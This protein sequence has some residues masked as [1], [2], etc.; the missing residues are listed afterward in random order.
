ML[1]PGSTVQDIAN[2]LN[3]NSIL[4]SKGEFFAT[5]TSILC[6]DLFN[7]KKGELSRWMLFA[8][9]RYVPSFLHHIGYII[10]LRA[11]KQ[12]SRIAAYWI[13]ATMKYLHS[14][15]NRAVC[16]SI[17]GSVG[18]FIAALATCNYA[19]SIVIGGTSPYP[20]LTSFINS[21][22]QSRCKVFSWLTQRTAMG[23]TKATI[24]DL[25]LIRTRLKRMRTYLAV[26]INQLALFIHQAFSITVISQEHYTIVERKVEDARWNKT[27]WEFLQQLERRQ[28]ERITYDQ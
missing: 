11:K 17:G 26:S 9:V 3:T 28:W 1:I 6:P 25:Y 24:A 18:T 10:G 8:F 23:R 5:L 7:L 15:W 12:M 14:F 20:A 22:P 27:A 21:L 16:E 19:V 13:V 4:A 2:G